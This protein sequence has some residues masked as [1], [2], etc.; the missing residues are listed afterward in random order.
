ME[1]PALSCVAK[2]PLLPADALQIVGA[3]LRRPTASASVILG[4]APRADSQL[5]IC[6]WSLLRGLEQHGQ[7]G[8]G[9]FVCSKAFSVQFSGALDEYQFRHKKLGYV[10]RF[11]QWCNHPSDRLC[12][13][14]A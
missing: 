14:R 4:P 7:G 6:R 12:P 9:T 5:D 10:L 1:P 13:C 3:F 2:R 11:C 8:F